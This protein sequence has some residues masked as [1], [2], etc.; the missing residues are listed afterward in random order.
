MTPEQYTDDAVCFAMGLGRFV[1][2]VDGE[3][4]RLVCRP[5]FHPEVC[6]TLTPDEVVAVALQAGL[7][8]DPIPARMPEVSER[9]PVSTREFEAARDAFASALAEAGRPPKWVVIADGM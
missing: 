5:S 4:L 8:H 7:W 9:A 3:V 2:P 1:P 6:I